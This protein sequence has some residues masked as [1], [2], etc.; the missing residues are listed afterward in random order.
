MIEDDLSCLILDL[1]GI[2]PLGAWSIVGSIDCVFDRLPAI[3]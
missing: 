2:D 1:P 3:D